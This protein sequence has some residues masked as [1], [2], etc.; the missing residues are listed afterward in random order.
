MQLSR[1]R[2]TFSSAGHD[3]GK[4]FIIVD[5][6]ERFAYIS[7]GKSRKLKNPKKKSLKHLKL[8]N[9]VMDMADLTDK[10]LR[11]AL[12]RSSEQAVTN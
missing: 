8:T 11:S 1:G 7:D 9:T 12:N 2:I 6:D 5:F 3:K 10:K 4:S